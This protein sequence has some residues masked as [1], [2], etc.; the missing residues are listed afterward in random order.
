MIIEKKTKRLSDLNLRSTRITPRAT[1]KAQLRKLSHTRITTCIFW[2]LYL[3]IE[4]ECI[5]INV[6]EAL[7]SSY[8]L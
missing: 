7:T 5:L 2:V 4:T 6:D 8:I 1:S 3:H